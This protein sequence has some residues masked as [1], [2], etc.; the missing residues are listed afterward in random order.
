[1]D[2]GYDHQTWAV[3]SPKDY[4]LVEKT[5]PCDSDVH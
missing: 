2:N 4:Y 5:R 1:M 3:K